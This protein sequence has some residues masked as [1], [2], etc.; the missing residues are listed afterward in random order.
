MKRNDFGQIKEMD[1]K[2][3]MVKAAAIKAEIPDLILDK[4]MNKLKDLKKISKKRK[5]LAQILTVL[6]QKELLGEIEL[7]LK[8]KQI[9]GKI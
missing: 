5:D 1:I 9:K 2:T 3:L 8:T 6:K 4:N 7:K